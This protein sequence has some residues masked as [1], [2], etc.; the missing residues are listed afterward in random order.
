MS[1]FDNKNVAFFNLNNFWIMTK[2]EDMKFINSSNF[3]KIKNNHKYIFSNSLDKEKYLGLGWSDNN[4]KGGIWSDGYISSIIFSPDDVTKDLL[5]TIDFSLYLNNNHNKQYVDIFYKNIF[6]KNY[7]FNI[8]DN[9]NNK[10]F[11][12]IKKELIDNNNIE[13]ILNFRN[14]GSPSDYLESPDSKKLGINIKAITINNN[15]KY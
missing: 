12:K 4:I 14:P 9:N 7:E 5:I 6:L 10:I 3:E 13:V 11:F 1:I 2:N 15:L 8:G